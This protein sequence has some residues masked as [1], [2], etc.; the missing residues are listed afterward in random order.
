M[1][2]NSIPLASCRIHA[3]SVGFHDQ[4][5]LQSLHFSYPVVATSCAWLNYGKFSN[6]CISLK[7][8]LLERL[9][10]CHGSQSNNLHQRCGMA[11]NRATILGWRRAKPPDTSSIITHLDSS[12]A[13]R[14]TAYRY[15][16]VSAFLLLS[17][18]TRSPHIRNS[19]QFSL[20]CST[21]SIN[22]YM[23]LW[24]VNAYFWKNVVCFYMCAAV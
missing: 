23:H 15:L 18:F 20:P 16:Y 24:F 6:R 17:I 14:W 8:I 21:V 10:L 12:I 13:S 9:W 2:L 11:S 19:L 22:I 7:D 4:T 1:V 3:N 5:L